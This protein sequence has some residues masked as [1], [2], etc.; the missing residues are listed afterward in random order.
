MAWLN[1]IWGFL[2]LG[3]LALGGIAVAILGA[4]YYLQIQQ[5]ER[6]VLRLQALQDGPPAVVDIMKFDSDVHTTELR[7]AVVRAQPLF[8][9]AYRLT[10]EKNG[11]DDFSYM[12]PLVSADAASDRVAFGIALYTSGSFTFDDLTDELLYRGITDFGDYGPILEYNGKVSG[13]GQWDEMVDEALAMEGLTMAANPV[14]IRP[15]LEGREAAL[16]P[17]ET[18]VFGFLSKVAG[19]IG[20]LALGKIVFGGKAQTPPA[21][22][23]ETIPDA[24]VQNISDL[25]PDSVDPAF[26]PQSS[27]PLRKQ[28]SGLADAE[29]A[30][31]QRAQEPVGQASFV[32]AT[33]P[34][35]LIAPQKSG[36]GARKLLIGVIGAAFAVL[37][38]ST[39]W[40]LV[41]TSLENDRADVP[42][43]SEALASG[44]AD[45]IVPDA[46]PDRHWTDIDV[47]P[48]IEWFVAKGMLAI[49]GDQNAQMTLGIIIGG[50]FFAMFALRWYFLIRGS[51]T[52]T[53]RVHNFDDLTMG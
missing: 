17:P 20:L 51:M 26:A 22:E 8:D 18:T 31:V 50:V 27:V 38:A 9:N 37:L 7:E 10:L 35:P 41:S 21:R 36:F 34:A 45:V 5:N 39:V 15:Y 3:P 46:D 11:P 12:V 14:I 13:L 48:V 44:V 28:R 43:A 2:R 25:G 47:T 19:A 53:R 49:S 23:P 40:G 42:T 29:P 24:A 33:D 6:N 30:P 32:K 4:G 1:L 16:T 52:P